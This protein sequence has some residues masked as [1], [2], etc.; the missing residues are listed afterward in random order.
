MPSCGEP[1]GNNSLP[2]LPIDA[3]D[4]NFPSHF[5]FQRSCW[6]RRDGSWGSGNNYGN[7]FFVVR[8]VGEL[9]P[10]WPGVATYNL[11]TDDGGRL[12]IRRNPNYTLNPDE[13]EPAFRGFYRNAGT[14]LEELSEDEAVGAEAWS[15][16]ADNRVSF[17]LE[18]QCVTD[19]TRPSP[20][21]VEIQTYENMG[22]AFVRFTTQGDGQP[23]ENYDLRYLKPL[24]PVNQP[25]QP[26]PD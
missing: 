11:N 2:N 25:C 22:N 12:I 14:R 15:D 4:L 18:L 23:L 6:R 24:K 21:L 20:Y 1:D 16:S 19:Y 9:Y 10:R 17:R 26:D 8:W 3:D 7:D 13:E 5:N